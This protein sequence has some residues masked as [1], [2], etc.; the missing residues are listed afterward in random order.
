MSAMDFD[1]RRQLM[2]AL[3]AASPAFASAVAQ[4]RGS[5]ADAPADGS[6]TVKAPLR[7]GHWNFATRH[8]GL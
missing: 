4:C 2:L 5:A 7:E 1:R 6:L 8:D 3:P